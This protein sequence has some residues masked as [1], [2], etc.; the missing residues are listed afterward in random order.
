MRRDRNC[1]SPFNPVIEYVQ[2]HNWPFSCTSM[3]E[4]LV[5]IARAITATGDSRTFFCTNSEGAGH[6]G[7]HWV[8]CIVDKAT[9]SS[10][11]NTM[12]DKHAAEPGPRSGSLR[13]GDLEKDECDAG[14]EPEEHPDDGEDEDK[15]E[16]EGQQDD[17]GGVE[18]TGTVDYEEVDVD[19]DQDGD[20]GD[21]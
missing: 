21:Y 4:L 2:H 11:A 8:A 1:T 13:D 15:E 18:D 16:F 17:S 6:S 10:V 14:E 19:V 7:F 3:D 9:R 20:S 5:L 12:E